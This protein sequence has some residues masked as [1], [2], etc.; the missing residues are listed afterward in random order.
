MS[1]KPPR[2]AE[3]MDEIM[4]SIRR[5]VAEQAEAHAHS[6]LQ[7]APGA[8]LELTAEMRVDRPRDAAT[9][10][11]ATSDPAPEPPAASPPPA[12]PAQAGA[13]IQAKPPSAP[14][15]SVDLQLNAY[16]ESVVE[17]VRAVLH[18][19]LNGGFGG[20]FRAKLRDFIRDE[21]AIARNRG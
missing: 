13:A 18:D 5:I 10:V 6:P 15:G 14:D 19:E 11:V 7:R 12:A 17:I 8:V 21:I 4:A 1:E 9:V 2:E 16:E 3:Q 20:D